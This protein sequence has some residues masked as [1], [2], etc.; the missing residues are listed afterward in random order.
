MCLEVAKAALLRRLLLFS[1][2][3]SS[4]QNYLHDSLLHM[5]S[6]AVG[7]VT[8]RAAAAAVCILITH[9]HNIRL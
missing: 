7:N 3:S 8:L 6:H 9:L 1:F 5:S 4:C 2:D